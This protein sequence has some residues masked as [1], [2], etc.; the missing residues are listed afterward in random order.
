[1]GTWQDIWHTLGED[2]S[3][4]GTAAEAVRV[5]VR[6]LVAAAL[7]GLLGW[8][9]EHVGKSAGLRTH[10]LV[11]VGAAL[12]ILVPQRAGVPLEHLSRVIQGLVAGIGFLGAGVIL[13]LTEQRVIRGITTA[14]TIWMTAAVGLAAGLGR[15]VTAV[16]GASLAFVILYILGR[17]EAVIEA[18]PGD[19]SPRK[20]GGTAEAK[21]GE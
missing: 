8:E 16:V 7:G 21:E 17:L 2:F 11:A 3:D 20:A 5:V 15:E 13:K 4:L 9:R 18:G 1:M 6:L 12:F 19:T 14:A 10:M